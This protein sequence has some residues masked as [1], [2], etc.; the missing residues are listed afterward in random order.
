M[1]G[2]SYFRSP[3]SKS[4]SQSAILYAD[5]VQ[6]ALTPCVPL[7]QNLKDDNIARPLA[8]SRIGLGDLAENRDV[9]EA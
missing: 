3:H 5:L 2:A 7:S 8:A 6:I 4:L 1:L 9:C